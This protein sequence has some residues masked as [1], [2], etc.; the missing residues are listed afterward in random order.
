MTAAEYEREFAARMKRG[1]NPTKYNRK[2]YFK[3]VEW[4][5]LKPVEVATWMPQIRPRPSKG[6]MPNG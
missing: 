4:A 1:D 6:A 3:R 2:D 5:H